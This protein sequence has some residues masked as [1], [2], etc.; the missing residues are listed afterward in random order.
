VYELVC[1]L[2]LLIFDR[3]CYLEDRLTFVYP[4]LLTPVVNHRGKEVN[5]P[6]GYLFSQGTYDKITTVYTHVW[7]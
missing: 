2:M 4:P 7:K 3:W 5:Y 1:Q 6:H